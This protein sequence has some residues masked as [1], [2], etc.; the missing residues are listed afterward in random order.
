MNNENL[1]LLIQCYT[2]L[3]IEAHHSVSVAIRT[4]ELRAILR[5]EI[6]TAQGRTSEE[7]QTEIE[8][9]AFK[10]WENKN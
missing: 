1:D 8:H 9:K 5:N 2:A 10:Y 6:S 3:Q 7:V 4:D